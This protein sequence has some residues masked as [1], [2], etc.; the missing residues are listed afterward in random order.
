MSTIDA[1]HVSPAT[2]VRPKG[3]LDAARARLAPVIARIAE[4]AIAHERDRSLPFTETAE[5]AEAG[6]GALRIPVELGG[7]GLTIVEFFEL[8]V[9]LGAADSN[10]P[11]AWRNHIAFVE[12]RLA[13]GTE[14]DRAWLERIAGGLVIGGAWSEVGSSS[15]LQ[16]STRLDRVDGRLRLTGTKYYSTGS[17]FSDWLSV[18]ARDERGESVLVIVDSR[19]RGVELIDDWS[20]F[21]QR[22]T[23]SGTTRFHSVA[24]E[25]GNVLPFTDRFI[26]QEAVYQLVLLAALAGIAR[27]ARDDVVAGV[28]RR[29]R[30]YPHGLAEQP[31][32]DAQVQEV[33]GR[34][35]AHAAS[36]AASVARG[37]AALQEVSAAAPEEREATARQAAIAVYEAQLVVASA[38]LD[39]TT[40]LFDALGSSGV[41]REAGLDRHWRNARTLVSHNPRI[42]KER[43]VGDWY[44]NA[45]DPLQVFGAAANPSDAS[46]EGSAPAEQGAGA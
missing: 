41:E 5:L 15:L 42:Y 38:T 6:F 16:S 21:G 13:G 4:Q 1:P 30:S 45:A 44:L 24:V 28:L 12:D 8:L 37:A 40:L 36:A 7:A 19:A 27:A 3:A 26:S 10:Q 11:Q 34:V 39:A 22:T 25:E 43:I 18:F 46:S 20:G 14:A 2:D 17:I 35:A 23:G 32:A 29:I 33:V 9:E 31:R